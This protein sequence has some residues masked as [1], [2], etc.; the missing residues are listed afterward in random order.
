MRNAG[1]GFGLPAERPIL[2]CKAVV[3]FGAFFWAHSAG[4]PAPL[5][6]KFLEYFPLATAVP[7]QG[8]L[9]FSFSNNHLPPSRRRRFYLA[10]VRRGARCRSTLLP[11]A[12]YWAASRLVAF[13]CAGPLAA[14]RRQLDRTAANDPVAD[15]QRSPGHRRTWAGSGR[16]CVDGPPCKRRIEGLARWSGVV[17]CPAVGTVEHVA[18]WP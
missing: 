3:R 15:A 12:C 1:L 2:G 14:I 8:W 17:L 4:K 7:S 16:S 5:T 9:N 10:I 6:L 11:S 18:R 13:R